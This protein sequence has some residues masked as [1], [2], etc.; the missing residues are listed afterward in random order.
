MKRRQAV[1]H[2]RNA[3]SRDKTSER[4]ARRVLGQPRSTQRRKTHVPDDEPR[5]V[6]D[7]IRL[8]TQ[9]G[10]YVYGR[11]TE[12]LRREGWKVNHKRIERFW[13]REGLKVARK[14]PKRRLL[15]L[16]DGLCVRLR[17]AEKDHVWS[18]DIVQDRAHDGR[19]L[20]MLMP[21]VC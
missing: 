18:Y 16:N 19:P 2:A 1:E 20:R 15:W 9:Y 14:H 17:P 11:V 7:M 3:V 8:A 6:R 21:N 12:L 13:R 10:R 4:R 5:L